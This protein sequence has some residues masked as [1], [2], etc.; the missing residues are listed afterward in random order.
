MSAAMSATEKRR[1]A[2]ARG[3]A[4][5]ERRIAA[6]RK[7]HV[8]ATVAFEQWLRQPPPGAPQ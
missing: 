5:R 3:R 2:A 1:A 6:D 8:R 7:N 4:E